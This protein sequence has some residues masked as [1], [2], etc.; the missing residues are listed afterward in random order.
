[1]T[2]QLTH[3]VVSDTVQNTFITQFSL[4]VTSVTDFDLNGRH[5]RLGKPG[6]KLT[7]IVYGRPAPPVPP[8]P[9]R[10]LRWP[11]RERPHPEVDRLRHPAGGASRTST[12]RKLAVQ[13]R[14]PKLEI[15]NKWREKRMA[16]RNVQNLPGKA[17]RTFAV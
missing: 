15:R 5:E 17:F 14:N 12:P 1:M 11:N 3:Q 6:Q 16:K 9:S 13:I 8:L 10:A 4:T 7:W 2:A